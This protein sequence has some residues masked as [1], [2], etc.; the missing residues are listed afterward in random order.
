[1]RFWVFLWVLFCDWY[2]FCYLLNLFRFVC[3][4]CS[5]LMFGWIL[6]N[7]SGFWVFW[8]GY[9]SSILLFVI[10]I[11]W[12]S[13]I[14]IYIFAFGLFDC[15]CGAATCLL[16]LGCF[17]LGVMTLCGGELRWRVSFVSVCMF[18]LF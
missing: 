4:V 9:A 12:C 11:C 14:W 13:V 2:G 16:S 3:F 15:F 7:V 6:V 5:P 8:V 10:Y 1:M 18:A 17:V